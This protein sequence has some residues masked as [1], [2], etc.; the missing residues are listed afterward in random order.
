VTRGTK[1]A[2]AALRSTFVLGVTALAW[3][4]IPAATVAI[5]AS[6][7]VAL[8]AKAGT[9]IEIS[10]GPLKAKL[11]REVSE[12][13]RLV[14]QLREFASL[15]AKA[16]VSAGV[17]TGRWV[18]DDDWLYQNIRS[19]EASLREMGVGE[20]ALKSFRGEFVL[21]AI[22]DA[23]A[24]ALGN[25]Q[26]AVKNGKMLEQEWREALGEFPNRSA[27]TIE[28]FLNRHELMNEDRAARIAD[29]RWM[30]DHGDVKDLDQY[31]R[32]QRPVPWA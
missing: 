15:Q 10:F 27:N 23:G 7:L 24:M 5:V 1:I 12:A 17:R 18:S 31:R 19:L 8:Q 28:A 25:G 29:M 26:I 22:N 14:K 4:S 21:Y 30:A 16:I 13:E 9:L 3:F 11:E 20:E 2:G 6:I 32:T